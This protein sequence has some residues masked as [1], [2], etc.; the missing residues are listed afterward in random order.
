MSVE[1]NLDTHLYVVMYYELIMDNID[2]VTSKRMKV[3]KA[4]KKEKDCFAKAYN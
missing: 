3:S 1:V 2:E 4:I